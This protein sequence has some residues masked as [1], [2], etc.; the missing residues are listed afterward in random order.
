VYTEPAVH[1][2]NCTRFEAKIWE[3]AYAK[4][5]KEV[6]KFENDKRRVFGLMLGQMS[7]SSKN[8]V[9]ETDAGIVAMLQQNPRLLL[10]AIISTHLTDNR[11]R[12]EHNLY[13]IENALARYVMEPGDSI[14][15]YNQRF[16]ALLS[17]VEEAYRRANVEGHGNLYREVQQG[18]KFTV[19]LNSTYS[20]YKQYYE[21]GLKDWPRSLGDA[22]S[23]APSSSRG[24]DNNWMLRG[25]MLS[26]CEGKAAVEVEAVD[27]TLGEGAAVSPDTGDT[28]SSGVPTSGP[29]EYGTRKGSCYVWRG[30][31]L[32]I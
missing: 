5:T 6:D 1:D 7:E 20:E 32:L 17:G 29:S 16:R 9:K 8:R 11:L 23:E 21:D 28:E 19:G 2:A 13:K 14:S 4:Y 22:F 3:T 15:F 30:G 27:A 25:Q 18:L 26:P 12:A 24:P 31:P 10:S